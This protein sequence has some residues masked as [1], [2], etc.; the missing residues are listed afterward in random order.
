MIR[1]E[2]IGCRILHPSTLGDND[3]PATPLSASSASVAAA[4]SPGA[5]PA[6]ASASRNAG[7]HLARWAAVALLASGSAALAAI[8]DESGEATAELKPTK[9]SR[10]SGSATFTAAG[11]DGMRIKLEFTGLEPNSVHGL[12]VHEKGDCSAPDATSAGPHFAL[13]GQQH[14]AMEGDAFHAGDLGNVKADA[15]GKASATLTVPATKLTLAPGPLSVVGRALVL[16]AKADDLKSQ[17]AGDSGPRIACGVIAR[18]TT[19]DG[20]APMKPAAK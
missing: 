10:A 9:D 13:A 12:H 6:A 4:A 7:H 15:S 2:P 18:R 1:P 20:K 8:V 3:M 16:H 19:Q 5:S 11:K 14:G 17:P